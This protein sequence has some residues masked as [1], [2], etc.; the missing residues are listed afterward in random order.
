[1]TRIGAH[2]APDRSRIP[3]NAGPLPF[4][5]LQHIFRKGEFI[6][7]EQFHTQTVSGTAQSQRPHSATL[8]HRQGKLPEHRAE[9]IGFQRPALDHIHFGIIEGHF[10]AASGR[11]RSAIPVPVL[12]VE[13]GLESQPVPRPVSR[14]VAQNHAFLGQLTLLPGKAAARRQG[15][16][17]PD[18][19]IDNALA[20]ENDIAFFVADEIREAVGQAEISLAAIALSGIYAPV[21]FAAEAVF[22]IAH[23][24]AFLLGAYIYII[25]VAALLKRNGQVAA[26]PVLAAADLAAA[27]LDAVIAVVELVRQLQF[28][29]VRSVIRLRGGGDAAAIYLLAVL[30]HADIYFGY[31]PCIYGE[32]EV[33]EHKV[34]ALGIEGRG[35][36]F[37]IVAEGCHFPVFSFETRRFGLERVAGGPQGLELLRAAPGLKGGETAGEEFIPGQQGIDAALVFLKISRIG[38]L[39]AVR[40]KEIQQ[41]RLRLRALEISPE[42][43]LCLLVV[44]PLQYCPEGIIVV[45]LEIL[46]QQCPHLVTEAAVL[47]LES[48][49][50]RGLER[51]GIGPDIVQSLLLKIIGSVRKGIYERQNRLS[52]ILHFP[53]ELPLERVPQL[54]VDAG[55]DP[56]VCH[57]GVVPVQGEVLFPRRVLDF[58]QYFQLGGRPVGSLRGLI[59]LP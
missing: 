21:A 6:K 12:G 55:C 36:L 22:E 50:E 9:V 7:S 5:K 54:P 28:Q 48:G 19:P 3:G 2:T 57:A 4:G 29:G 53:A 31:V 14:A 47:A 58:R 25:G 39:S 59:F 40:G 13:Y 34:Q 23:R 52:E 38:I 20:T 1:M 46:Q 44:I 45:I 43:R 11:D 26:A 42:L 16:R 32:N 51:C 18:A 37:R 27:A 24:P 56:L 35:Y 49:I 17:K 33:F 41:G 30:A 8:A 10:T 15:F